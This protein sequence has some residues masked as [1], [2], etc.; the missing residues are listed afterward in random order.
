MY[1]GAAT[2]VVGD[3][4]GSLTTRHSTFYVYG[5]ASSGGSVEHTTAI[6]SGIV[7]AMIGAGLWLWMAWKTGAGRNWA[8]VLS[9]V[10]F[11]FSSLGLL[12]SIV[13]VFAFS[14]V[15]VP[16]LVLSFVLS[17]AGW[18]I[19][20]AALILLWQP[21][22]SQF[23]TFAEQLKRAV[24]YGAPPPGYPVPGYPPP[25]YGQ[26]GYGQPG[27]GQPGYGEPPR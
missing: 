18:G 13:A 3:I 6:A 24:T 16:G 1:A 10:F 23:F 8:R 9:T 2:G 15:S 19:G 27:Y 4:V 20:L 21:E 11:G 14:G 5:S 22:S 25:G 26:P 12:V 17:L 7:S